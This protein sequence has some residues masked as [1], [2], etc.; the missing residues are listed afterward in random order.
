MALGEKMKGKFSLAVGFQIRYASPY[1]CSRSGSGKAR[2]A[3]WSR[4][5]S[6]LRVEHRPPAIRRQVGGRAAPQNWIYEKT[7][8]GDIIV[9]QNI[10]IIDT[11]N[12]MLGGAR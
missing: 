11:T 4:P 5:R 12:W 2:L 1:V 6:I 3:R 8:S 7:I 10:H 9:E